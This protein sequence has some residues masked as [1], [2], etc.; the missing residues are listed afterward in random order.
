MFVFLHY[1][2]ALLGIGSKSSAGQLKMLKKPLVNYLLIPKQQPVEHLS[3]KGSRYSPQELVRKRKTELKVEQILDF[4][5]SG[6]QK[7]DCQMKGNDA[8]CVNKQVFAN[9]F[10]VST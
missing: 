8:G 9:K 1:L 7:H 4:Y 3:T 6:G 10:T 5:L 2:Y